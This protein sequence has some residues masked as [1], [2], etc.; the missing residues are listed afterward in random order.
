MNLLKVGIITVAGI[1]LLNKLGIIGI[2]SA[3]NFRL[4]GLFLSGKNVVVDLVV[5][6]PETS[7]FTVD[8][9]VGTLYIG[10]SQIGTI[11][12][13]TPTPILPSAE[14]HIPITINTS[15]FGTFSLIS[16]ALQGSLSLNTPIVV[17]GIANVEGSN[18]PFNLQ[19]TAS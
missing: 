10:S 6:N 3:L 11:S 8:G 2:G 17:N 12:I 14:T 9:V 13:L 4:G 18:I 1:W 7:G 19:Y 5:Q 16:S 15:L